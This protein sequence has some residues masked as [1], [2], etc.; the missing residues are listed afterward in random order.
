MIRE[1]G[2]VERCR[3]VHAGR[4]DVGALLEQRTRERLIA[5]LGRAEEG[6]VGR[7]G[8]SGRRNE[9]RRQ[10]GGE[11]TSRGHAYPGKAQHFPPDPG[12]GR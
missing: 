7:R 4:V 6:A 9:H 12:A 1:D 5:T 8:E 2:A 11:E 3:A 10:K